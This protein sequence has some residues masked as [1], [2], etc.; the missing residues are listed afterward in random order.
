MNQKL[1]FIFLLTAALF[2]CTPKYEKITTSSAAKLN[3][4]QDSILF[5]T[6]FSTIGSTTQ[7]VTV[8][9]QNGN[10]VNTSIKLGGGATS[11]Y[12]LIINGQ[13]GY[14]TELEIQGKDSILILITVLINPEDK[15]LPYLVHDSIVFTTNGN[16][17]NIQLEA[18]GQDANFIK[19][20]IAC[21]A[22]WNDPK[23]YVLYNTVT[24]SPGCTL[25]IAEG[26]KVYA[27]NNALLTINGTLLVQGVKSKPVTFAGD[28]L[29]ASYSA[30][31]GQWTGILF[32]SQ[33][34]GN[35]INWAVIKN[36]TDGLQLAPHKN[37]D[38]IPDLVI[39]NSTIEN[40]S[41]E[42]IK[43][44]SA[45]VYAYNTLFT[46]S[47]SYLVSADGGGHYYFTYCTFAGFSPSLFRMQ[48][49]LQFSNACV[50]SDS[51]NVSGAI[52][53]RLINT[54]VW[55]DGSYQNELVLNKD[56]VNAFNFSAFNSILYLSDSSTDNYGGTGNKFGNP[57]FKN[58][59]SPDFRVD[60]ATSPA[61]NAGI[62]VTGITTDLDS[63]VRSTSTPT[64]GAYER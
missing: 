12:T 29:E 9:N 26:A 34:T 46:N 31:P 43:A 52:N 19:G 45:N 18:Y 56:G 28:R 60:S 3:F 39:S 27:H 8:Y 30:V 41:D 11:S 14:N 6:I 47:A 50:A 35:S 20:P 2:S 37:T 36:A 53:A 32:G 25:T 4:S 22:V 1:V 33:S 62:P 40:M 38:T 55:G 7:L 48:P 15:N 10:A 54:I 13:K 16:V 24:V 21:N 17:Q 58:P 64:I 51:S 57:E 61:L 44:I 42:C 59:Y 63:L 5:D 23:P 49:A